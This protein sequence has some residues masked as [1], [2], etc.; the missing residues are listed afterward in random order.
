MQIIKSKEIRV[1]QRHEL[2]HVDGLRIIHEGYEYRIKYDGTHSIIPTVIIDRRE[3][4]KRNFKYFT[5]IRLNC[6]NV[7]DAVNVIEDAILKGE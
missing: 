4:G 1:G 5:S 2:R 7:D 6:N 3:N